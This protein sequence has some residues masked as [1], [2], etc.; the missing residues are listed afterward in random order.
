MSVG[1]NI[2]AKLQRPKNSCTNIDAAAAES[3][4]VLADGQ[5]HSKAE[6]HKICSLHK[7]TTEAIIDELLCAVSDNRTATNNRGQACEWV[8]IPDARTP[9]MAPGETGR[10]PDV[11]HGV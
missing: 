6:L 11:L 3:R 5:W 4:R 8:C 10:V 1:A 2:S 7:V 9:E